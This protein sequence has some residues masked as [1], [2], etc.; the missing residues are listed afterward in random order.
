MDYEVLW[1]QSAVL[2][3]ENVINYVST[4]W[5][6]NSTLQFK[7]KNKPATSFAKQLPATT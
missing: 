1:S 6:E 7:K 2:D 3:L 4:E 5:G